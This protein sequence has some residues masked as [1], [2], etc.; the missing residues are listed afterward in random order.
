MQY[1]DVKQNFRL[2]KK[3]SGWF[4]EEAAL[5]LAFCDEIQRKNHFHGDI[6]EI[7]VHHGRSALFLYHFLASNEK[8]QVCDL[9]GSQNLNTSASGMGDKAI[10]LQNKSRITGNSSIQV[11]E[12][13]SN[14]LTTE[15]IG[16]SYRMFHVDGGHSFDEAFADLN[17]AS[18]ALLPYGIII[19]D[20]PFRIEWPGV[21]EAVIEFL[22]KTPD[23][24]SLVIG[25]NKLILVRKEFH[26]L[27]SAQLDD[28][29]QRATYGLGLPWSYKVMAL[30]GNDLRCFYMPT[31]LQNPSLKTRLYLILKKI[32]IK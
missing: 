14:D 2:I 23:F 21:T 27:Y 30:S 28:A 10:F 29:N 7:G 15:E 8:M 24:I 31:Y 1:K 32:K 19:L 16:N 18:K 5:L 3:I 26:H 20:D 25:F 6:F 12:K 4:S 11:H 17:L 22:K 13:L 9:F